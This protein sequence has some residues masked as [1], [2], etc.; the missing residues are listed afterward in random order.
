[1]RCVQHPLLAV[2]S[3]TCFNHVT[4]RC[5]LWTM[6]HLMV[7]ERQSLLRHVIRNSQSFT[8]V[9]GSS[10]STDLVTQ[11]NPLKVNR[12]FGRTYRLHL[13]CRIIRARY[14]CESRWQFDTPLATYFHAGV[15]FGLFFNPEYRGDMLLRNVDWNFQRTTRRYILED[16]TLHNDRC[17]NLKSYN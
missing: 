15:L 12:R 7:T 6:T 8:M 9:L 17:E 11:C 14:Q 3:G 5:S 13:Q 16:S 4:F 2:S 10:L 1:M